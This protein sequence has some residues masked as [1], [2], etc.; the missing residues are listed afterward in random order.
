MVRVGDD[1]SVYVDT[2]LQH[3]DLETETATFWEN[4]TA[5]LDALGSD[6]LRYADPPWN[7]GYVGYGTA[8]D[9]FDVKMDWVSVLDDNTCD[10]C[11]EMANG[12]PYAVGDMDIW[13]GEATCLNNCRCE[14][15][16]EEESWVAAFG[17]AA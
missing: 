5:K 15:N 13:P 7:A 17:E 4:V 1:F 8:L 9:N 16:A 12:S 14:I 3:P 10:Q 6:V 11:E 2:L